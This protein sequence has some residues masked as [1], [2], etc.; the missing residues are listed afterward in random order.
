MEE[1]RLTAWKKAVLLTGGAIK[2]PPDF[3]PPFPLSRSTAG[4][5]AGSVSM[6]FCFEGTRVK[7]S[8][9]AEGGDFELVRDG[10]RYRILKDGE[11][12]IDD[13]RFQPTLHHAPEQA[14]FNLAT[15]CIYKC[16]F[17]TSP[18]LDKRITKSLDADR[19][20]NMAIKANDSG[21]LKA[22]ALT[23]A[24]VSTPQ[25]TV[26]RMIEVV[27]RLREALPHVPIGVEPYVD[28]LEQI[29][30]LRE[31]GAD[32]IKLN[33]E[34]YDREIF[35]KV[36]GEL[37]LDWVLEAISHAVGVF[38]RGKVTSNI[39]FG[40][41]ES[42][43]NLLEGV[44]LL[45]KMGCIAVLRPLRLNDMN[46]QA[47]EDVLGPLPPTGPDRL[48][49]LAEEHK[50]ILMENG[51]DTREVRTMCPECGCCDIVPFRDI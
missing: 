50:R 34:T 32:E 31:A 5:G 21:S 36:C 16:K 37:D 26:E 44:E 42:D 9:S 12:L 22:I 3:R 51:L 30:A 6:V 15:E 7:K 39:I 33:I 14:F 20:V 24:V 1:G 48:L 35:S 45:A 43:E 28:R 29:D 27:R 2:V 47:M 38:G 46:R 8:I 13:V 18:R 23:S 4:P 49:H 19:I 10:E 17:C 25:E 11:T 40:M 41:G